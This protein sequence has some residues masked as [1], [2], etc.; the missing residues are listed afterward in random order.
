M[1]R[2]L[3][4]EIV[5][6][7]DPHLKRNTVCVTQYMFIWSPKKVPKQNLARWW[8]NGWIVII[9][10]YIVLQQNM[11]IAT[12][13]DLR[14]QKADKKVHI[15]QSLKQFLFVVHFFSN[16]IRIYIYLQI[17]SGKC[18]SHIG[19]TKMNFNIAL[20]FVPQGLLQIIYQVGIA[21]KFSEE[22]AKS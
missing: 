15:T 5:L 14:H 8:E 1:V 17:K 2:G 16:Q 4:G 6:F 10:H 9:F 7:R 22:F 12:K 13:N 20:F 11:W 18:I 21:V 3:S 19:A